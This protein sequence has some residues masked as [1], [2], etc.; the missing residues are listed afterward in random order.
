MSSNFARHAG[1]RLS[2]SITLMTTLIN[3]RA[4]R[5]F[6][7]DGSEAVPNACSNALLAMWEVHQSHLIPNSLAWLVAI[8]F[9]SEP[10][11]VVQDARSEGLTPMSAMMAVKIRHSM[12]PA[13]S[14]FEVSGSGQYSETYCGRKGKQKK[15]HSGGDIR[16]TADT[17]YAIGIMC[18]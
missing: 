3:S 9:T 8:D 4:P 18:E 14:V 16:G 11:S 7:L 6:D 12:A 5:F 1:D 2:L 15:K 17:Y 13:L 10:L